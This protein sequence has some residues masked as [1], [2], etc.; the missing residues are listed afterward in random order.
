M[1]FRVAEG[2]EDFCAV[3]SGAGEV[4]L[5]L[6][7]EQWVRASTLFLDP[8][9]QT[10][11]RV[12]TLVADIPPDAV[13]YVPAVTGA[14]AET[15]VQAAVLSGYSCDH[16]LIRDRDLARSLDLLQRAGAVAPTGSNTG[17]DHPLGS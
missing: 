9:V 2:S 7:Q 4:T 14:L 3:L 1:A 8:A 11:Y 13:G 6:P 10:D 17:D 16:L 15:G 5:V 12:I